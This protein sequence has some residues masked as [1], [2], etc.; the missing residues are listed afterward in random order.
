MRLTVLQQQTK[1][2]QEERPETGP[3]V[4]K[5]LES[6][7]HLLWHGNTEEALERLGDLLMELSLIEARSNAAKKV[8]EGLDDFRTYICNNQSSSRTSASVD[9]KGKRL[10]RHSWSGRSIKWS[11]DDSSKNSRCNGRYA[12]RIFCC[13]QGRRS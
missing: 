6:L 8:V 11:A 9:G 5:R 4:S 12:G 13:R 7:K 1:A 3:E 2:L 10:A